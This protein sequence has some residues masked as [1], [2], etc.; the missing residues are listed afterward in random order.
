LAISSSTFLADEH[1][2]L[3]E[4]AGVDVERALAAA[5]LLD[6]HRDQGHRGS[7]RC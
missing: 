5:G 4:Q 7:F 3:A 6:H 1:D 2:P